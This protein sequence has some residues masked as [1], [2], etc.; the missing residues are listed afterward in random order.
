MSKDTRDKGSNLQ[1]SRRRFLKGA[2]ITAVASAM[3]G[4]GILKLLS[5]AEAHEELDNELAKRQ[6][7]MVVDLRRCDGCG[8]CVKACQKGH[9]LPEEQEWIKVY[10]M[11]T[12]TGRTYYMPRLCMQCEN[13]PCLRVCPVSAT[14]KTP[15]GVIVVDQNR[16]IGCRICMAA[17]PYDARYFNWNDPP[18]APVGLG[19]P[20]P[21]LPVPQQKGTVGKCVFCVHNTR[22]GK[23]PM[24]VAGCPM[25]ALY[26]GDLKAD[27]ATNGVEIVKL[28][29]FLKDNDAVH[30]KG[31]LGTRPRVYYIMGR[32]QT[33]E[34]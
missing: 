33:A 16:C 34:S 2:G 31:E 13:A 3:A 1:L 21:E 19:G 6:W 22:E 18:P 24:C 15:D 20:R 8:L 5:Q 9:F 27:L 11:E 32:G 26:V 14:Y 10:E 29:M 23:L 28:S 30:Y 25:L 12:T 7:V 4:S 17:C